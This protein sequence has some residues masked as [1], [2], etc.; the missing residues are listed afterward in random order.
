MNGN[1]DEEAGGA[2]GRMGL[3]T[4]ASKAAA[5]FLRLAS[6]NQTAPNTMLCLKQFG[7]GYVGKR[8]ALGADDASEAIPGR[9]KSATRSA[10]P[11]LKSFAPTPIVDE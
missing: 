7:I 9:A 3:N 4:A 5:A 11:V 1:S 6:T 10:P 2:G 8:F